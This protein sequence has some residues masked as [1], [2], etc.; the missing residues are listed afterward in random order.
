MLG[1]RP[2]L[3]PGDQQGFDLL[4]RG[5]GM[6][7]AELRAAHRLAQRA[8]VEGRPQAGRQGVRRVVSHRVIVS[9]S[10]WGRKLLR[11]RSEMAYR[12][13]DSAPRLEQPGW[14]SV[15]AAPARVTP[16]SRGRS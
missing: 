7:A 16:I 9:R 12:R 15:A 1:A 4:V 11:V 8:E 5:V 3:E 10:P 6:L 14:G 2:C 13:L